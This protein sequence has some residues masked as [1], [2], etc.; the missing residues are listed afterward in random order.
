MLQLLLL[1]ARKAITALLRAPFFYFLLTGAFLFACY[2]YFHPQAKPEI[3]ITQPEIARLRQQLSDDGKPVPPSEL[4]QGIRQIAHQQILA[5][6]A[7]RLGLEQSDPTLM[8]MLADKGM[9]FIEHQAN[10]QASN[11]QRQLDYYH[12]HPELSTLYRHY[13]LQKLTLRQNEQCLQ[14]TPVQIK[15]NLESGQLTGCF[16]GKQELS[17][18]GRSW[19][20][21]RHPPVQLV[22]HQA[23]LDHWFAQLDANGE[24]VFYRILSAGGHWQLPFAA[25]QPE[26]KTA[27]LQ[28]LE[29][30]AL[31][32][33]YQGYQIRRIK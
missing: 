29:K 11:R 14:L 18:S 23:Q 8:Q 26:I 10:E 30:Q 20:N 15:R 25:V 27:L 4:E 33:L 32:K 1:R 3:L 21:S 5:Q 12:R 7:L 16:E 22:N 19:W 9:R 2:Q 28:T 17:V 6:E 24:P 13:K 31:D